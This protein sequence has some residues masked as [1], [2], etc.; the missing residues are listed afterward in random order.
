MLFL[1]RRPGETLYVGDDTTVTVLD[2][3]GDKVVLGVITRETVTTDPPHR[4]NN[5]TTNFNQGL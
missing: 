3:I 1:M 5:P 2:V 4:T